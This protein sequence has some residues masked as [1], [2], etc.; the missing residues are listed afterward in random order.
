MLNNVYRTVKRSLRLII[1]DYRTLLLLQLFFVVALVSWHLSV[2]LIFI[3]SLANVV[4]LVFEL[5]FTVIDFFVSCAVRFLNY[6]SLMGDPGT[7]SGACHEILNMRSIGN[8]L[9]CMGWAVRRMLAFCIAVWLVGSVFLYVFGFLL[10]TEKNSVRFGNARHLTFGFSASLC[11]LLFYGHGFEWLDG[12]IYLEDEYAFFKE[13]FVIWAIVGVLAV[14]LS[15]FV[16][17][18][19]YKS[20]PMAK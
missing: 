7:F 19:R 14:A 3:S 16:L 6:L 9:T 5:V 10:K 8:S 18:L 11:V 2:D 15:N 1:G 17:L 13:F 4:A 20:G 12:G